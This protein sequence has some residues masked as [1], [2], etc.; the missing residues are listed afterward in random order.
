MG[1]LIPIFGILVGGLA[2]LAWMVTESM[3]IKHGY[4]VKDDDGNLIQRSNPEDA[5]KME[6]L[7]QEVHKL[8]DRVKVLERIAIEKEDTL[9]R[10][11]EELRDS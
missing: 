3:K 7:E 4:P 2:I 5:R 11:I 1:E 10:Q 6:S 8:R 9:T